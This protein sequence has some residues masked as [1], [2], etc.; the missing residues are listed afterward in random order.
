MDCRMFSLA[1]LITVRAQ[2]PAYI[3]F[4]TRVLQY[5]FKAQTAAYIG[6][7]EILSKSRPFRIV[8]CC[9]G[10]SQYQSSVYANA[11]ITMYVFKLTRWS[12]FDVFYRL[13]ARKPHT[14][15]SVII[16]ETNAIPMASRAPTS[17][18]RFHL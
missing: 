13:N 16:D 7:I 8:Y 14:E 12:I 6:L 10:Y 5:K 9:S 2:R 4:L 18:V 17:R 1:T 3:H 15:T 11:M